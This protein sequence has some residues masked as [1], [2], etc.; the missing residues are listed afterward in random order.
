[1]ATNFLHLN[2]LLPYSELESIDGFPG[3]TKLQ[4]LTLLHA[5]LTDTV[6]SVDRDESLRSNFSVSDSF[7]T[8]CQP[9]Y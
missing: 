1:M 7:V 9:H 4:K 6:F 2:L 5:K 8:V 3:P